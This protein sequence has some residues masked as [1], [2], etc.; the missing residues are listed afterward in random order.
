MQAGALALTCTKEREEEKKNTAFI[1]K[2]QSIKLKAQ[3]I[4]K[5]IKV[6]RASFFLSAI[7]C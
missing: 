4:I 7:S 5:Q 3:V 6:E 1:F 2:V